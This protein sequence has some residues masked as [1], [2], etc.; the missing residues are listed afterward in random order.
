LIENEIIQCVY[1]ITN[2]INKKVYIGSTTNFFVRLNTHIGKLRRNE[3]YNE[4]LQKDFNLYGENNFQFE[5]I[6]HVFN[7][8]DLTD[9]EQ[10]W[11]NQLNT[12]NREYG[13]NIAPIAGTRK[14]AK[15]SQE[16]IKKWNRFGE[17]N[18]FF[19]KE[20]S[21]ETK[22]I[23]RDQRKGLKLPQA[24]KEKISLSNM[25]RS[26]NFQTRQKI[27]NANRGS[28]CGTSKLTEEKVI[29]IKQMLNQ[30]VQSKTIAKKFNISPQAIC[31][32]KKNRI[33]EH[34]KV[35]DIIG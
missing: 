18:N 32:I 22:Q 20:H 16:R 31:S 28:K 34:V 27:G 9:R 1:K 12:V 7:E 21:E 14:G 26:V 24:I 23:F 10:V 17:N 5:I 2:L 30:G 15:I 35:G 33:W 3:N 29:E 6:E 4:F 11:I 19:G 8:N 13:Y 25:G